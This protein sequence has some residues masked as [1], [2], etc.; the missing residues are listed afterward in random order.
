[1][2]ARPTLVP[3]LNLEPWVLAGPVFEQMQPLIDPYA[4]PS[5]KLKVVWHAGNKVDFQ[6]KPFLSCTA[7]AKCPCRQPRPMDYEAARQLLEEPLTAILDLFRIPFG[8]TT[9]Y[10]DDGAVDEIVIKMRIRKSDR[11]LPF[12]RSPAAIK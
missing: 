4:F 3:D 1:M 9:V 12:N 10:V 11:F 2:A 8:S 6:L 5:A 7:W